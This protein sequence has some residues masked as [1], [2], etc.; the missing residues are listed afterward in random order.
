MNRNQVKTPHVK[1]KHSGER[2]SRLLHGV[3]AQD[4]LVALFDD[5]DDFDRVKTRRPSG[6]GRRVAQP[7]ARAPSVP[8]PAGVPQ[9]ELSDSA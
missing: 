6:S 2:S 3:E 8:E 9:L 4:A 1:A 5:F 7:A